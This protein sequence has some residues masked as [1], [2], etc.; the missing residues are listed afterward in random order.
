MR[1]LHKGKQTNITKKGSKRSTECLE[2]IHTDIWG[3]S[4]IPCLNGQKYFISFI[5][6]HSR[7]MYLYLLNEK[8]EAFDAFKTYKAEVENQM[9]KKIKIVRSDR[10]GEYY[11]RYTEK[12]QMPGPFAQ[13]LKNE[14]IIAQY[15]MS[16]TP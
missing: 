15:T 10:G 16:G 1:G 11:G 14:G 4:P 7:Y 3:P 6:D 8:S 13:F 5:D 2:I 9:D 12:G